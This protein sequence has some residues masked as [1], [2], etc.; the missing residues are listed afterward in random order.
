[1]A[2]E[3]KQNLKL[4]QSLVMT[5]QLQQAIKLLQLN[6]QELQE[7]ISEALIENP[8]LEDSL[9][10]SNGETLETAESL[11]MPG[12]A[13]I[14]ESPLLADLTQP[15]NA[16]NLTDMANIADA[17][18]LDAIHQAMEPGQEQINWDAYVSEFSDEALP[19]IKNTS[20]DLPVIETAL[21]Q[22]TSLEEHLF[23]Q[24][25]M[26]ELDGNE[27]SLAQL[28]IANLADDGYFRATDKEFLKLA[29]QAKIPTL[30]HAERVLKTVQQFDPVGVAARSL[31]E[32][33]LCQ[34]MLL[35]PRNFL[36]EK[37]IT[38]FLDDLQKKT[39]QQLSKLLH[40]SKADVTYAIKLLHELEPKPAERFE[41][42]TAQYITPDIFIIKSGSQFNILLNDDG[43]PKLRI[44]AVYQNILRG[45]SMHLPQ[46]KL[47]KEYVQNKLK[48]AIW[49][50]KAIH[51]RQSTIYKVAETILHRQKEFFEKG[52][53]FLKP[54][55]LKDVAQDINMHESTVSR[56]TSHKFVHTPMGVFELKYFFNS[57]VH[58]TNGGDDLASE[59]VKSKIKELIAAEDTHHPISD[60]HIA[61]VL[62]QQKIDIARRTV[63]K[64]REAMGIVSSSKRKKNL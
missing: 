24:L 51:N 57:G 31:S 52:A 2:I 36:M 1:M 55:I 39:L 59:T 23:W 33:L 26:S 29:Q 18:A 47:T 7:L 25:S 6:R 27:Q 22:K 45:N 42:S 37:I 64:Y 48:S 28:I 13:D 14:N 54:M 61:L 62:Q 43:L 8:L 49:L 41:S 20:E 19:S 60:E 4:A 15:D 10:A 17:P 35:E 21:V 53:A 30:E 3:L 11:E 5:P 40:C 16:T 63:A 9:E 58:T 32:C 44:S 12:S 46:T 34:A 56:V 38:D 50:I